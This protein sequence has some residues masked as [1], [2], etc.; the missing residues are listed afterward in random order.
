VTGASSGIGRAA[1]VAFAGRGS[2]VRATG[3]DERALKSLAEDAAGIEWIAA[4]LAEPGEPE[5]VAAWAGAVDVLVSSAGVGYEGPFSSM[6][7]ER[8]DE[9]TAINLT[10]PIKLTRAVLPGMLERRRGRVV[11][12]GSI[13]SHVPVRG[14]AAYAATKWGVAG[15]GE[16]LRSEL[17][18]TG[19]GVTLVSPGVVRTAFFDRRSAPYRR[20]SPR[21]IPSRQVGEAIVRAVERERDDVFV[22][23]WLV[24]PARLRGAWPGLYRRLAARFE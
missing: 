14:E 22:P 1:A 21:P 19:V 23:S 24:I 4:D 15:F 9:L 20:S 10:A 3:R 13:A 11:T 6:P 5:R 7:P 8:V 2:S 12:V 17:A 16:S 18:G